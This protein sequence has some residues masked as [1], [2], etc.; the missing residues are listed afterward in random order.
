VTTDVRGRVAIVTGASS[1]IGRATAELLA[2]AGARV[3]AVARS[4]DRL[5]ELSSRDG[6]DHVAT[7]IET[8]EACGHVVEQT[9][10]RL[11]PV[12]IL[13]CSAGR[14]GHHDQPVWDQTLEGW[15]AT[16]AV[17]LDAPFVLAK[18]CA[19]DMRELGWGRIV[20]V[21]STAGEIGAPALGPYCASKHGLIGL[22]RSVA[23]DVGTFGGTCNAVL[24]GWVRTPIADADVER[25]AAA[26]GVSTA[27][28]WAEHDASYPRG[29][30]LEAVEV[31]RVIAWLTS[32]DAAAVNGEALTVALGGVW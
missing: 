11:G 14:G 13:V 3:M 12:S 9:R 22:A 31:A 2:D 28:V 19:R 1:G 4:K 25:E 30:S 5:A 15:R 26:R 29:R 8:P 27:Q 32:D 18:A 16:M 7:S 21:S 24:P 6:I 10:R 17:N 20:M 23:H